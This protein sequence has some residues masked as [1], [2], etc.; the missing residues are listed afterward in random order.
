MFH[1]V[2][3][4]RF[5]KNNLKSLSYG[6]LTLPVGVSAKPLVSKPPALNQA[7][8]PGSSRRKTFSKLL[9]FDVLLVTIVSEEGMEHYCSPFTTLSMV[10][11][12]FLPVP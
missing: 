5:K 7:S 8:F 3:L 9:L 11:S 2:F 12:I 6:M 10:V 1:A 4:R